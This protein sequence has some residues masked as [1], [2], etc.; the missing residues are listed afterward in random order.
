MIEPLQA[1]QSVEVWYYGAR[2]RQVERFPITAAMLT[3][4]RPRLRL[5]GQPADERLFVGL[6]GQRP[7]LVRVTGSWTDV[8]PFE[9]EIIPGGS[10]VASSMMG[11]QFNVLRGFFPYLKQGDQFESVFHSRSVY[12]LSSLNNVFLDIRSHVA[13]DAMDNPSHGVNY[14]LQTEQ[15]DASHSQIDYNCD[16][17]DLHAVPGP[18]SALIHWGKQSVWNS[19]ADKEGITLAEFFARTGYDRHGL[20]PPSYFALVANPLR[21]DFRP[22][23]DSLLL[24]AGAVS[25][26]Q[27]GSFLFDPDAGNGYRRNTYKGN[28]FDLAGRPRGDRP[29]IGALQD[30]LPGA[31]LTTLLPTAW[32]VARGSRA[33][34]W[35]TADYALARMRPGDLLVLLHGTYRQPIVVHRSGTRRD[36]LHIVAENPP[37]STPPKFPT[38]GPTIID[39]S[40]M[41]NAPAVLLDG[42]PGTSGWPGFGW[43]TRRQRPPSNFATPAI[44]SSSTCSSKRPPTL[45]SVPPAAV[46]RSTS[47]VWPRPPSDTGWPAHSPTSAGAPPTTATTASARPAPWPALPLAKPPTRKGY[48]WFLA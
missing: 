44:A 32:T 1:G 48:G 47:A 19:T 27:V 41:G 28:E 22:L 29:T 17:K 39:A 46:T 31:R 42:W 40:S 9:A 8:R 34:P 16:W 43:S 24:G 37:Y 13:S 7:P 38:S 3:I 14:M 21:F 15:T 26:Q 45:A 36:F 6:A 12:H 30:P 23:P 35:A 11:V 18:L 25:R 33:A 10:I 5:G 20:T 2:G 4:G